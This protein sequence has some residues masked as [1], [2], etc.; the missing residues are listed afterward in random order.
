M[1][2]VYLRQVRFGGH[3]WRKNQHPAPGEAQI[4][5][6][7]W[8]LCDPRTACAFY[9]YNLWVVESPVMLSGLQSPD[10]LIYALPT[11]R[12]QNAAWDTG[13]IKSQGH[14]HQHEMGAGSRLETL[15]LSSI[16]GDPRLQGKLYR[17]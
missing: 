12:L 4:I 6:N 14:A 15:E 10:Y 7:P 16:L 1:E 8:G 11:S 17:E 2:A 9:Q 3:S 13:H 5:Q